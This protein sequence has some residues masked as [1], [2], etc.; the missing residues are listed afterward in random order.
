MADFVQEA[1]AEH[2]ERFGLGEQDVMCR[3]PRRNPAAP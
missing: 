1:I 2:A 3:T